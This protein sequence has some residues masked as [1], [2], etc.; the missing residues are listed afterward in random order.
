MACF[1]LAVDS[2]VTVRNAHT[3]IAVI[4][5]EPWTEKN[6]P[7]ADGMVTKLRRVVLGSDSADCPIILF[8][9]AHAGVI[10]L[11]HAGWRGAKAGIIE[12]TLKKMV[13]LGA[14][15]HQIM[16]SISP[17]ISQSSYEVGLEFHNNFL[18]DD[19]QNCLFFKNG[20][21]ENYFQFDLLGYV[22]K[23]LAGCNL[24]FISSEAAFD[25]YSDDRFFSC[26]RALHKGQNDFGGHLSC[27]YLK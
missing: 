18:K 1:D 20:N 21:K 22:A 10:G 11:A 19:K 7:Q 9:D 15:Y 12:E 3:N 5:D 16:A 27:I 14:E 2:L 4:V 6:K 17:C 23:R 13:S 8:V 26:R 24:K 25:T